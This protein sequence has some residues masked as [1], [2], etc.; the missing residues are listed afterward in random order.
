MTFFSRIIG[1]S[2]WNESLNLKFETL[3][4]DGIL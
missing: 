2:A 4:L 1:E 3:S